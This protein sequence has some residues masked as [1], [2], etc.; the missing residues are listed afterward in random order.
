MQQPL[1]PIPFI[2]ELSKHKAEVQ[3]LEAEANFRKYLMVVKRICERLEAER[4]DKERT[5]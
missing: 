2:R 5:Y 4:L 3:I 1:K